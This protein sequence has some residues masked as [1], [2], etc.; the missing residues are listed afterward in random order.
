MTRMPHRLA[1]LFEYPTLN[2]GERSMLQALE[3][4]DPGEFEM[5]ALAPS[6]GRLANALRAV[7]VQHVPFDQRDARNLRLPRVEVCQRLVATMHDTSPSL[8]HANSLSMG[9]LTGV[10]SKHLTIPCTAHLRDIIGLSR[11]AI[12]DLNRNRALI[13]VS[14]ATRDFHVAQGLSAE[15]TSVIVNGVDCE[16]FRPRPKTQ[17]LCRELNIPDASFVV[18]TVGQIGLRKGQDVLA[19]AAPAISKCVPYVEFVIVG[20]RNSSKEETITYE[21]NLK[22][23]FARAG[24]GARLHVLG[25]RDDVDRLMNEADLLVH[26]AKQEPLGRVLLEAAA[27]GLPIVATNVGGTAEIVADDLSARLVASNDQAELAGA[28][29]ELASDARL[30]A[31]LAAAARQ[32]VTDEFTPRAAAKHL[33]EVWRRAIEST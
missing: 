13:A 18:L 29:I 23:A 24:L 17:S 27:S 3:L 4:I 21:A 1:L 32:R 6:S 9:R 20:E 22:N 16:R 26:P 2:G 14:Q 15:R 12:N 31:R 8:L 33:T 25:Y 28:V 5:I 11:A 30:R 10:A 19:A 7:S